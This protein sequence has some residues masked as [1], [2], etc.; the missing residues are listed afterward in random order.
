MKTIQTGIASF[1]MSGRV[2]H[3][4]LIHCHPAFNLKTIVERSPKGSKQIYP[5]VE[6]VTSFDELIQDSTMDLIIVNTPDTTHF[7]FC[8]KALN[9][10]KHVVVEKPFTVTSAEAEKLIHLAK[11]KGLMISVFQNRRWDSDFLTVQKVI[12]EQMLGRLVAFESHFDRYR[13][14]IKPNTWKE[15]QGTGAEIVYNLGTH[16]I[17][18]AYVLFGMPH[19]VFAEIGTQRTGGKADDSYNII[20][21]YDEVSVNL[22]ASYLVREEG[23]RYQLHGTEG[24]FLKWGMDPQEADLA[25]G[26]LPGSDHWGMEDRQLWGKLN[27]EINGLHVTGRVE[28]LPGNYM[29]YYES[30]ADTLQNGTE[31]VVKPEQSLDVIKIVE[32]AIESNKKGKK[33]LLA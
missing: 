20:L 29:M 6:V 18:Q 1:G 3:A 11:E 30:I 13:N 9:A 22:K 8:Q 2:F 4:P 14:F 31:L 33:V 25:A 23:P 21:G 10:G 7:D 27:T 17:D 32:A 15:E 12:K 16:M 24:S 5:E 28:S 19:S 26:K